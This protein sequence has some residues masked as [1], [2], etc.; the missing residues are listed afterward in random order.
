ASEGA[1]RLLDQARYQLRVHSSAAGLAA[2]I[3]SVH[4][5][6]D[7]DR[8][9]Q[10]AATRARDMGFAGMLCIHPRQL[11]PIHRAFS[12]SLAEL[13]WAQRVLEA[14]K[15]SHGAFSVDGQMVDAPVIE[16]ARRI[17][18]IAESVASERD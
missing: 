3:E 16:R 4:P 8:G 6:I 5:A 15:Q 13:A 1:E 7:D 11:E 14:A 17:M 12:P 2:P 18:A 10:L 9:V